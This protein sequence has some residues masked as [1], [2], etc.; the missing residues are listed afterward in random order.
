MPGH[1]QAIADGLGT[2]C[3]NQHGHPSVY[4]SGKLVVLTTAHRDHTPENCDDA[5]L[6]AGCQGCHLWYDRA[7]HADTARKTREAERIRLQPMLI[8]ENQ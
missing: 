4:G 6:F 1:L 8:K 7:H 3:W 5:N 2:R